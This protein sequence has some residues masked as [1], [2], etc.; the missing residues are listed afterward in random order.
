MTT[1]STY[2]K[3]ADRYT[4]IS[5][6]NRY[7]YDKEML[8]PRIY[9]DKHVA[10]YRQYLNI[11]EGQSP[12]MGD[13]LKFFF[14]YQLNHMY[15]RYFL[16][17]FV[18]RQNDV[19]SQGQVYAGNWL[20][21]IT[22]LDNLR[23]PGQS[24]LSDSMLKDPS[25]NTYFFLPLLLGF[26][27]ILWQ[28]KKSK[29]DTAILGLLFFFTGLA[30]VIYLNQTPNQPRE[31]DYAYA[32]SFYVFAIWIGLGVIAVVDLLTKLVK[33]PAK[34]LALASSAICLLAVPA[35]LLK[36]N[37]ND[38]NRSERMMTRDFAMN[39]LNSCAP[40]AIL[41]TYADND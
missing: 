23:L 4:R 36:E 11:P 25:R 41:F 14:N 30:I 20:S 16:W 29:K 22:F 17:N 10:F 6:N 40:N 13:N 32:G 38:H 24:H 37:W 31:R 12:S 21:G 39:M 5:S 26:L 35:L 28:L 2:R 9:S 3:D 19:P 15:A 7:V 33:V 18:G 34:T 1:G 27:G 8:F